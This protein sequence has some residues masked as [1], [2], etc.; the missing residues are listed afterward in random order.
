MKRALAR[1][2]KS[3][4]RVRTHRWPAPRA[5]GGR[6]G[7]LVS[8]RHRSVAWVGR[9]DAAGRRAC[10]M[11]RFA[12][13]GW[14]GARVSYTFRVTS[15][16]FSR[17][18]MTDLFYDARIALRGLRRAPTF[19]ATAVLVLSIG[20]GSATAMFTVSRA[21]LLERLPITDPDRVVVLRSLK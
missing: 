13:G 7:R 10:A 5:R 12:R 19:T 17:R 2:P 8:Y 3:R 15:S 1:P 16:R 11:V 6:T 21:V 18:T 9:Q 14:I 20:I 4:V